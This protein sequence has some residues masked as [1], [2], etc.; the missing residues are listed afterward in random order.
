VSIM[1]IN[2]IAVPRDRF[3]EF[4]RRFATQQ[5]AAG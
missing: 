5:P 4:E 3:A 1:K 2:A